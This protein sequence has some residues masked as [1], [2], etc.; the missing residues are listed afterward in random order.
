LITPPLTKEQRM[1]MFAEGGAVMPG[2][3]ILYIASFMRKHGLEVEILD[4]EGQGLNREATVQYL[5]QRNPDIIGITT[6]TLSI[7]SAGE[8]AQDLKIRIP[9]VKVFLGGAHVTA[10]PKETMEDFCAI[11]GCV[12][13]DG[14]SSFT[15]IV[16]NIQ[17]GLEWDVGVD[18]VVGRRDGTLFTHPKEEH[19]QELDA[20]PFPAWDLLDGFP[21]RYRPP[22]HSYQ[23]LPVANIITTRGCP[24]NCSFCDRS[25]FGKSIYSHSVG[26]VIEMIEYLIR[27]FGIRE[28]SI[29]DDAFMSSSDWVAKFC[30]ELRRRD[31]GLVWSCN[32]RVNFVNED[33]LSQMKSAGCRMI[34]Y[35]IESGSPGILKKMMKGIT[36]EQI[37]NALQLTRKKGIVSKGFFM[38]GVPGESP[39]TLKETLNFINDIPLDELN[40]NFFTPFPGSD[41]FRQ[42]LQEGFQPDFSQMSM[43]EPV[44]I[45]EGLTEEE[46]RRYQKRI[47]YSFYLRP[48]KIALYSLRVLKDFHELKRIHRMARVLGAAI[49]DEFRG[50]SN[51]PVY[52][53]NS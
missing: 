11:D 8:L 20:L 5:T 45:P 15:K 4:A 46:L 27:E 28:V 39:E 34:S 12:L 37:I 25:V 10:L 29:K 50:S 42:V 13:G 18:G 16:E 38:I 40:I 21:L 17:G 6:T 41:L 26:Y 35:G 33:M 32:A 31:L 9:H 24:F 14:E 3:G 47:I 49:Y 30:E 7:I 36:K 48:S 43:L 51:L 22:F 52:R 1:G 23:R 19:L 2:L 44:Y 53:R